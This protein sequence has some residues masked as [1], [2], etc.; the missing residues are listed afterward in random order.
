MK[1]LL[2]VII[3]L[4]FIKM[5]SQSNNNACEKVK[6]HLSVIKKFVTKTNTDSSMQR[7]ESIAFLENLS[8]IEGSGIGTDIGKYSVTIEDYKKW[9]KWFEENKQY[10][11]YN[12]KTKKVELIRN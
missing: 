3:C 10:L 2:T 5:Y 7:I 11:F 1:Y 12:K 9:S 8:G 4:S 6:F